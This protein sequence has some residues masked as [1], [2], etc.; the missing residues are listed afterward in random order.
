MKK[1]TGND[2]PIDLKQARD[3]AE[4]VRII[5]EWQDNTN[6]LSVLCS[7]LHQTLDLNAMLDIFAEELTQVVPFAALAYRRSRS[8]GEFG[9]LLGSGGPH[10]C[11]Y[12]LSLRGQELGS[13]RLDR[14]ERFREDELMFIEQAIGVLIQP[15]RNAWLYQQ[16]LESAM[17][18]GLT[19]MGNRRSLDE[20]LEK[21]VEQAHRYKQPLSL[22]L[23]DLDHFKQINDTL[24]HAAGDEILRL[25]SERVNAQ[26]R[27]CDQGFRYGGEEFAIVLPHTGQEAAN[28]VAERLR[29]ALR[30]HP[31]RYAG[32]AMAITASIGV[33]ALGDDDDPDELLQATDTALYAAKNSGRDRVRIAGDDTDRVDNAVSL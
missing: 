22:L 14:R 4:T 1:I 23:L 8:G 19:G 13:L 18:D 29:R 9:Y 7:R 6:R 3:A 17:T 24:G 32:R 33:A 27:S 26:I 31:M 5:D 10:H 11:C 25:V 21:H 15:L 20:T 28:Q 2:N 30:E 12:N 16:A